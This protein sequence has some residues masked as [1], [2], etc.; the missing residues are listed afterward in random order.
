VRPWFDFASL[1][2]DTPLLRKK[3]IKIVVFVAWK[4]LLV[5]AFAF[6]RA[7]IAWLSPMLRAASKKGS[8]TNHRSH[9]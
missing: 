6:A 7:V 9:R 4:N 1:L 3:P 2:G 5:V 8:G